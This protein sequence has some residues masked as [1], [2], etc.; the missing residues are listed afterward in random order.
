AFSTFL[1]GSGMDHGDSIAVDAAGN[2]YITGS[3][4]SADFPVTPG[5]FQTAKAPFNFDAFVT[6]MNAAGTALIYST[7][8]GG[9]NLDMGSDIALDAA[10]NAYITG[11]TDSSDL[12]TTPGA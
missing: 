3:T 5:A 6:K 7:Y 12:P 10:G 8:F 1:G 4:L 2:A 11:Q 9:A